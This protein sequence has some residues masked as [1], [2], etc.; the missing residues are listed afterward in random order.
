MYICPITHSN[1]VKE[2]L[3]H[4]KKVKFLLWG[5]L[6]LF[7]L[8]PCSAKG[9]LF[10]SVEI[11]FFKPFHKNRTTAFSFQCQNS[12]AE[13]QNTQTEYVLNVFDNQ[14]S[15]S[16]YS[17]ELFTSEAKIKKEYFYRN[18]SNAPPK[19]ILFRCLRIHLS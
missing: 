18:S 19:Y 1:F 4:I 17:A 3:L 12:V 11:S 14:E 5:T 2:L 13:E 16:F 6:I 9:F 8:T 10:D 7:S 15:D